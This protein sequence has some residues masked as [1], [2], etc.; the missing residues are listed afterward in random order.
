[1]CERVSVYVYVYMC[2]CV[3]EREREIERVMSQNNINN[4]VVQIHEMM[5]QNIT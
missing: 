1:V 2:V 4:I 3:R 5:S